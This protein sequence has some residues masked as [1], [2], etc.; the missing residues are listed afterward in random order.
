MSTAQPPIRKDQPS[1]SASRNDAAT[2]P[3]EVVRVLNWKLLIG[4]LLAI[5]VLIPSGY[6]WHRYQTNRTAGAY[7][8]RADA[9][10]REEKW[11]L[12]AD[13][14]HRYLQV[15][16]DAESVRIRLATTFDKAATDIRRKPR[17]ATFYS[18]AVGLAPDRPD[19]RR[20]LGELLLELQRFSGAQ[21][22]A[23]ALLTMAP[24]DPVGLR[25]YA[26]AA[27]GRALMGEREAL[28]KQE[29]VQAFQ[30][31]LASEPGH[32]QLA[33][34]MAVMYRSE[35]IEPD[36]ET[37]N[38]LA[39]AVIER[40]VKANPDRAE[41]YLARYL[42]RQRYALEGMQEDI[43][44]AVALAPNHLSAQLMAGENAL[45]SGVEAAKE[46]QLEVSTEQYKLAE[47]YYRRVIEINPQDERGH[48]GLG[49]ALLA[50]HKPGLA[51]DVWREG[52]KAIDGDGLELN[53]QL[54][55]QFITLRRLEE[56]ERSLKT[57][58]EAIER[59]APSLP[60]LS[61]TA[62]QT[63]AEFLRAKWHVGKGNYRDAITLLR[64]NIITRE[65]LGSSERYDA[66][67]FEAWM[68]LTAC[69]SAQNEWEQAA[70]AC[71]EAVQLRPES[72]QARLAA[73]QA[74]LKAGRHDAANEHLEH[75]VGEQAATAGVWLAT[76]ET[77]LKRELSL[78]GKERNWKALHEQITNPP[79]ELR[80]AWQYKL[81]Q[82]DYV[83]ARAGRAA[84]DQ[85]LPL[86]QQAEQ[87]HSETP[88]LLQRL[89]L[90]YERLGQSAAAER[91]LKEFARL[92]GRTERLYL[93]QAELLNIRGERDQALELLQSGLK[94]MP[95]DKHGPLLLGLVQLHLQGGDV[96]KAHELLTQ[97][98][99]L[100]PKN[101]EVMREL[102][103]FAFELR[104]FEEL[105][106]WEQELRKLEGPESTHWRY[107]RARRLLAQGEGDEETQLAEVLELQQQIVAARPSWPPGHLLRGFIA[108]RQ[109]KLPEAIEAYQ[110]A[111][112]LGENRLRVYEQLIELL[113][114]TQRFAEAEKYLAQLHVNVARSERLSS[115]EISLASR[116]GESERALELA[117]EAVKRRPNDPLARIRLGHTLL[118]NGQNDQAGE[119]FRSASQLAPDDVQVWNGLLSYYLRTGQKEEALKT[120]QNLPEKADLSDAQRAF[121]LAQGY[122]LLGDRDTA[123]T[124]YDTAQRLAPEDVTI[125]LKRAEFQLA[126]DVAAAEKTLRQVLKIDPQQGQARRV[127]AS[128]LVARGGE[129]AWQEAQ[130][131]L[132]AAGGTTA[133]SLDQR[134]QASL[135][136]RR[137]GVKNRTKARQILEQL[138]LNPEKAEPG[139]RLLLA[140]L[141]EAEGKDLA[142]R[143]QYIALVGQAEPQPEHVALFIDMLLRQ[144]EVDEATRWLRRLTELAPDS[145]TTLGLEARLLQSQGRGEEIKPRIE[146]YAEKQLEQLTADSDKSQ[147]YLALGNLYTEVEMHAAAQVWYEKLAELVPTAY[148]PL[149]KCLATQNRMADAV[150]LCKA[151]AGRGNSP[152]AAIVLA[153]V[154][155]SGNPTSADYAL[156]EPLFRE[157]LDTHGTNIDLLFALAYIRTVQ[158]RPEDAVALYKQIC[159]SEPRHVLALNNLAVVL[160]ELP[161]RRQEALQ[162]IDQAIDIAGPQPVLLDTKAMAVLESDAQQAVTLLLE[163]TSIPDPNP[164]YH[165]HLAFAYQ[166]LGE[167]EQAERA[168]QQARANDLDVPQLSRAD[169]EML[170]ALESTMQK[171]S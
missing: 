75:V 52:L 1:G 149:A 137:G 71:D 35:L 143:E 47:Q 56:A 124:H 123:Q 80:D 43:E 147:L 133:A 31:A 14:L 146:S 73:A 128:I 157:A 139:D 141:Y 153:S 134:L 97:L 53:A 6:F 126:G 99:R 22:Q 110:Q 142:A 23:E 34:T 55:A 129:T 109:G 67:Q 13:Y 57:L 120:L 107:H 136:A 37:R 64:S 96:P 122:E 29:I 3:R 62:L 144:E 83:L 169:A 161:T 132:E 33:T 17:A 101:I 152:Q 160:S 131:L 20:R 36:Q 94:R 45:R 39:D 10:E 9:L 79:N 113:Y 166:R 115:V 15:R 150:E 108:H 148:Q 2:A 81:L 30:R 145:M 78:P 125:L 40:M 11:D 74:W 32:L 118:L 106:H 119:V 154:L 111:I 68:L 4:T 162:Y 5:A 156:A 54:T 165:L 66:E 163:A 168:L 138:I 121:I 88:E 114:Q 49:K 92:V 42:Y 171:R 84:I 98:H 18:R 16:P 50:Q 69:Y 155:T 44:Q 117:R 72:V 26:L 158:Q 41:A 63:Y 51:V 127:L 95:T 100:H 28:S 65:T 116:R 167:F 27:H 170:K 102:A 87:A 48:L 21:E 105:Q 112:E 164:L 60:R 61:R 82:A 38:Q 86:L 85:A 76:V 135:L 46:K 7:L 25:V 77:R 8:A 140:R 59:A 130:T 70:A 90:I 103:D 91:V 24:N 93:V 12:A 159:Q 58:D 19:L 151:Q 104:K 89:V